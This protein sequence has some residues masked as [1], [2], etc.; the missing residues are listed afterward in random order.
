M[1]KFELT[2][3]MLGN[4]LQFTQHDFN[5]LLECYLLPTGS[6]DSENAFDDVRECVRRIYD[7]NEEK[8]LETSNA[9]TGIMGKLNRRSTRMRQNTYYKRVQNQKPG[10]EYVRI[11]AEG[12]SWFLF[13]V[14]VTEIVD[15]LE[16]R[17]DYLI[18]SDAYGGDWITNIIYEGQY[19]EALSVHQPDVFLLSGGGNDL[20]GNNRMALMV[21]AKGDRQPKYSSDNPLD[22][23][24]LS[25]EEIE[26]ITMAQPYITKDFYAFILAMKLQYTVL[27][28][29][30]YSNRSKHKNMISITHGYG[31][32]FPKKG[33][34]YSIR[35][36]LQPIVNSFVNS[37]QWLFRPLMIKGVL[38]ETLQR[39]IVL[40]FIYEF[41]QLLIDIANSP[42]FP[43]IY[44][45]DCRN[46]ALS[47][48]DWYDELHLK[49]NVYKKV[50][51]LYEMVIDNRHT[52]LPKV[53]VP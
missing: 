38:D 6:Y 13:P 44:H 41:N 31:Y 25:A 30:L 14:F 26:L 16:K 12:D 17:K 53:I 48:K 15:W 24:N 2:E 47:Q 1:K 42:D 32:P 40:T 20:V 34:N 37:G 50:A 23:T 45:I 49:S 36:P 35:Y 9:N 43:N 5:S 39:A 4:P 3:K 10:K 33:N 27:F 51:K 29:N 19:I 46:L 18:Y 8:L 28:K 7:I 22:T 52:D 21:S 11:Y